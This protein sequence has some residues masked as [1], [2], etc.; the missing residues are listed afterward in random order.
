M[1]SVTNIQCGKEQNMIN[2]INEITL[3]LAPYG[4]IDTIMC[5]IIAIIAITL[6]TYLVNTWE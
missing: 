4:G 2:L 1:M 6:T 5:F 3:S